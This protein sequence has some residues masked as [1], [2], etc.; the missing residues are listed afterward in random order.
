M[1]DKT[2][3]FETKKAMWL[4]VGNLMNL[5]LTLA[6]LSASEKFENLNRTSAN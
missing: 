6:F 2:I 3:G 5:L 1:F 4:E